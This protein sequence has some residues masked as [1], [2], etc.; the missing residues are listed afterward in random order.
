MMSITPCVYVYMMFDNVAQ[1]TELR[2]ENKSTVTDVA[3]FKV[4]HIKTT[5][6]AASQIKN[7]IYKHSAVPAALRLYIE[8]D[9][10]TGILLR[11]HGSE[12]NI[13]YFLVREIAT[14]RHNK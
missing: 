9:N 2:N 1:Q 14:S 6:M 12:P 7:A 13:P 11:T 5:N 3:R 4:L 10:T 8:L